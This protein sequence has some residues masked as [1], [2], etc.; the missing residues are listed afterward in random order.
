MTK[1]V[2]SVLFESRQLSG[3]HN[4][5]MLRFA[6][7][8]PVS[9]C[10][11]DRSACADT[12]FGLDGRERAILLANMAGDVGNSVEKTPEAT[13]PGEDLTPETV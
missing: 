11:S 1:P 9:V 4:R 12:L 5:T 2:L 3:L 6:H 13:G 10:F 7:N 8:L